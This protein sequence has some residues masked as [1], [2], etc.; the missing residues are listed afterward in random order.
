MIVKINNSENEFAENIE[1]LKNHAE[2]GTSSK[3][4]E[5]AVNNFF[6]YFN[7]AGIQSKKLKVLESDLSSLKELLKKQR[8]IESELASYL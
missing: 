4:A 1:T 2:V 8:K 7:A 6:H 5:F 3:A